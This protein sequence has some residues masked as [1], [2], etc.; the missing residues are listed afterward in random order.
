MPLSKKKRKSNLYKNVRFEESYFV[1]IH[2]LK[3]VPSVSKRN[4]TEALTRKRKLTSTMRTGP[5]NVMSYCEHCWSTRM[6]L[7]IDFLRS[8]WLYSSEE[9]HSTR[10]PSPKWRRSMKVIV[11][12]AGSLLKRFWSS[13]SLHST[14][15]LFAECLPSIT[16]IISMNFSFAN[17]SGERHKFIQ[18]GF[19][20][21]NIFNRWN[22]FI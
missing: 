11:E 8:E 17:G 16:T 18:L 12:I 14:Q 3:K 9:I 19:S 15:F 13:E 1:A 10:Y 4:E 5:I 6:I 2:C 20:S 22:M 7:S 21:L